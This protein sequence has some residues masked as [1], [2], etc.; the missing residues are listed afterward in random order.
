MNLKLLGVL[1]LI[2]CCVAN[3]NGQQ[4]NEI[5]KTVASDREVDD[6]YGDAVDIDGEYAAVGAYR[7]MS[8][9]EGNNIMTASGSVYLLKNVDGIWVEHQKIVASDRSPNAR[10]G[11]SLSFSGNRL[12]VGAR[13]EEFDENGENNLQYAG[14]AYV[15]ELIDGVWTEQ[16]KL[17]ASDRSI[18]AWFGFSVAIDGENLLVAAP[19]EDYDELGNN[20]INAAGAV[21]SY[22]EIDGVW[23]EVQKIVASDRE[24]GASFGWSVGLDG[25]Y[26][27]AGAIGEDDDENGNNPVGGAGATYVFELTD[28]LWSEHSRIVAPERALNDNFGHAV[29][30]SGE[31]IVVG[32]HNEDEDESDAN[33]QGNAGSAYVIQLLGDEWVLQQ[34]IVASDRDINDLFAYDVDID[35]SNIVIGAYHENEGLGVIPDFFSAGSAYVFSQ[36][37]GVWSETQKIVASDRSPEDWFAQNVAISDGFLIVGANNEDDDVNGENPLEKAGSAYVY[38][39]GFL[40][41]EIPSAFNVE[42]CDE[43]IV[44]S[45]DEVYIISGIYMDTIPSLVNGCDSVMTIDVTVNVVDISVSVSDPVI[46]ANLEGAEYQWLDCDDA[47]TEIE[48][49]TE[50]SFTSEVNGNFSV[51]ITSS[52]CTGVSDCVQILSTGTSEFQGAIFSIFPNP[53]TNLLKF[54]SKFVNGQIAVLNICGQVMFEEVLSGKSI[55]LDVSSI[56]NGIYFV[57]LI[58]GDGRVGVKKFVKN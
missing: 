46:T 16:Q 37:D 12:V 26:F 47:F 6:F 24:Y 3:L 5:T 2:I 1:A 29:A 58:D 28:G 34:K 30:I 9:V 41:T 32:A 10:F 51:E 14:A 55:N 19:G 25:N 49:A 15:F 13:L 21:Y 4:W 54:E 22:K 48:G 45:G 18:Q 53:A 39:F 42:V 56:S 57:Q 17:V 43:Y 33:Y 8:D 27:A 38:E 52:G 36:V 35:G 40:C 7:E 23:Q 20:A 50:Q 31:R 44:P 11:E